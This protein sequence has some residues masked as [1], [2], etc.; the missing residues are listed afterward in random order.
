MARTSS[1]E[2]FDI[3]VEM[4]LIVIFAWGA[5]TSLGLVQD[6]IVPMIDAGEVLF[7]FGNASITLGRIAS[8]ATLLA[9]FAHR[10]APLQDTAGVDL[11]IVYATIALVVAPPL[12]PALSDTLAA[13]PAAFIAF[14]VQ[15]TGFL[16]VSYIN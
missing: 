8:I 1:G 16:L 13:T 14:T 6:T 3:D 9:V 7:E 11:W 5:G 2:G 12:F 10:D 4:L 15:S